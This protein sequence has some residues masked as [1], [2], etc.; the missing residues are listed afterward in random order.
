MIAA[1]NEVDGVAAKFRA[2]ANYLVDHP[3]EAAAVHP[4]GAMV[5][6]DV[7]GAVVEQVAGDDG[8]TP[9]LVGIAV[10]AAT[11]GRKPGDEKTLRRYIDQCAAALG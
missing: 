1:A 7:I 6:V 10:M 8:P 11:P 5:S 2:A 4:F 9:Q 3:G